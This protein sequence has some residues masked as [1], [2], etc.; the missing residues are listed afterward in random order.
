[1]SSL[2][3]LGFQSSPELAKECYGFKK[4]A[5]CQRAVMNRNQNSSGFFESHDPNL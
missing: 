5:L 3:L 2:Q 1:M 4:R